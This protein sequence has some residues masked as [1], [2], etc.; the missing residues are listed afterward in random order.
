MNKKYIIIAIL[1]ILVAVGYFYF[2]NRSKEEEVK[3][4]NEKQYAKLVQI[5]SKS[6]RAGLTDM[7]RSLEKYY[8]DNKNYPAALI[9]L[10]PKYMPNKAFIEDMIWE[11]VPGKNNFKLS[12]TVI[13]EGKTL[14]ASI[15]KNLRPALGKEI[16]IASSKNS[17]TAFKK[18]A[19][20]DISDLMSR[21]AV[22]ASKKEEKIMPVRL[23]EPQFSL[24]KETEDVMNF[25]N[26]MSRKYLVWKDEKGISGFG[27]VQYPH[28]A[29]ISIY[30]D[31]KRYDLMRSSKAKMTLSPDEK[32][33]AYKH[34][35]DLDAVAS[36]QSGKYLVWKDKNGT[37]GFGN[38][39]YPDRKDIAYVNID[40]EW[41]RIGS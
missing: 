37:L 14:V 28:L 41:Q 17:S 4:W 23:I 13:V 3:K 8:A 10:Y 15:D 9:D 35:K 29:K 11:Y 26:E 6:P 27:N 39:Q 22:V 19:S 36:E 2:K 38:L 21:L 7:A 24:V 40:G 12:K 25:E 16:L 34:K 32:K 20:S 30:S 18:A 31:G 33:S 1:T 5:A